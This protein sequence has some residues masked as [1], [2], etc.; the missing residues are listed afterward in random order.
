MKLKLNLDPAEVPD[1]EQI[2]KTLEKAVESD[3]ISSENLGYITTALITLCCKCLT[4]S[5]EE[6]EAL[7]QAAGITLM[8]SMME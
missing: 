2:A 3:E 6:A 1:F 8:K 7:D 4:L 5:P